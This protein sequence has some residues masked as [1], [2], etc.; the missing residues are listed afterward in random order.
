MAQL[1]ISNNEQQQ[2]FQAKV[3][4]ELAWLEYRLHEGR[5]VLMHTEVPA[6]LGGRGIGT[7]LVEFAFNY[8]RT[9]HLPVKIYC[10]FVAAYVR[11]H[12]EQQ[13]IVAKPD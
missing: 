7:A 11:R 9:H 12:P 4:G 6:T 13:D 5:I 1:N 8:A 2:Q 10:P 3:D